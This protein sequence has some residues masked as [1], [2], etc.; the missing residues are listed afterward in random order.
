MR[1]P[2]SLRIHA[3]TLRITE[4]VSSVICSSI[5]LSH[6]RRVEVG[7]EPLVGMNCDAL[8]P[9]TTRLC[10]Q[11]ITSVALAEVA[12]PILARRTQSPRSGL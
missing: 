12:N 10:N 7:G 11:L 6:V 3:V 9:P 4:I 2:I 5:D 1:W 8:S